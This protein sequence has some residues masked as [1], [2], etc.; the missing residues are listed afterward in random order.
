MQDHPHLTERSAQLLVDAD[1]A[2]VGIDSLNIDST[3]TGERP[4]HTTLL[5]AEI[6]IV[7]HLTNLRALSRSG[8]SFTAVP[9]KI[10]GA[11]TFTVRAF[12]TV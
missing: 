3:E 4:V 8:F 2:C 1:V 6:P 7:E 5:G 11:G 9:P 10:E 12:A